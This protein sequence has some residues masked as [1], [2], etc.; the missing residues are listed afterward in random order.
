VERSGA[1]PFCFSGQ[2]KNDRQGAEDA[3]SRKEIFFFS[4]LGAFVPL[5]LGG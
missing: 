4:D 1:P 2:A 5:R 3:K